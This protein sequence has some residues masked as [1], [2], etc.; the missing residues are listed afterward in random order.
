MQKKPEIHFTLRIL[1][2]IVSALV[3]AGCQGS[4]HPTASDPIPNSPS[5]PAEGQRLMTL[6]AHDPAYRSLPPEAQQHIRSSLQGRLV[7]AGVDPSVVNRWIENPLSIP[8]AIP[9]LSKEK[10]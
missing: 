3:F 5:S 6:L 4:S 1:S 7:A 8:P 10:P 2:A 9:T